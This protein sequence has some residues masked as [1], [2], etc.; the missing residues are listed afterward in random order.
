MTDKPRAGQRPA[1]PPPAPLYKPTPKRAYNPDKDYDALAR[2]QPGYASDINP[3]TY[4]GE[5]GDGKGRRR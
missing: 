5:K 4:W 3:T 1:T 2:H